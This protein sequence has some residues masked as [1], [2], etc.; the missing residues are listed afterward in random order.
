M[1]FFFNVLR[2]VNVFVNL[3]YLTDNCLKLEGSGY[4]NH[5]KC[6][7]TFSSGCPTE[8]YTDDRLYECKYKKATQY[9]LK[10]HRFEYLKTILQ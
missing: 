4:L 1:L 8:P 3:D 5:Y 10:S 9:I 6:V 7:D 2:S